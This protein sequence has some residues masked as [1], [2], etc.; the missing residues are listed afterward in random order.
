MRIAIIY[1][2]PVSTPQTHWLARSRSGAIAIPDTFTD[3]ARYWLPREIGLMEDLLHE[4]GYDTIAYAAETIGSLVEFL[5]RERPDLIFNCCD[6]LQGRAAFE[7]NVAAVF[8]LMGIP[9]TGSSSLTLG[10]ALNKAVA[11]SLFESHGVP[12]PPWVVLYPHDS[13]KASRLKFPMIVKPL[14]EDASIGIDAHSIVETPAALIERARFV[15]EEFL[16]PALAEEFIEGRELTVALL[17]VAADRL[18]A[19]PV[20][21][22]LFDGAPG[23]GRRLVTYEAKWLEDSPDYASTVTRCPAD[24]SRDLEERVRHLA[25]RAATALQLRDYG[26]IDLRVRSSD[27]A[28]FVLEA[29]PNPDLLND[30]DFPKAAQAGGR[31]LGGVIAEIVERAKERGVR[32][33]TG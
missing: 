28:P 2:K 16:Q 33:Q 4:A 32:T 30:S 15:W 13:V 22:A 25:V 7:S 27:G 14:L 9:F 29:N 24:L 3:A 20:S 31:T 18:V 21:E 23:D 19:L 5:L 11:K 12:T 6:T 17:A 8:E 10:M 1:D 26:R